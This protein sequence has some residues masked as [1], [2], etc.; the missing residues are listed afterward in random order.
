MTE[1]DTSKMTYD[2]MIDT[3]KGLVFDT[4]DRITAKERK[5]IDMALKLLEQEPCEDWCDIPADEMTL[6][7]AR[8]AVKDL[9]KKLA[10][11]LE[12]EP[13]EDAELDFVQSHKK[14]PVN[15]EPYDD[16]IS[17]QAVLDKIKE[18]CFS[19]EQEWVDFRVSQGSN[20]QRDL[21]INFIEDLPS[22]NS[23]P[24]TGHWIS[25]DRDDFL[26]KCSNCNHNSGYLGNKFSKP[27][28]NFCPNC[29]AKME[30]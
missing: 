23:Q 17:R 2:E 8:Q 15:L 25:D 27:K 18:I 11:Y 4:F 26:W 19:R 24:K 1:L 10:E 22:V 5:A 21:I 28:Y 3:L 30:I 29:G 9:R 6:E 14:I 16:T 12:Q 20:G 7:Q 13:C